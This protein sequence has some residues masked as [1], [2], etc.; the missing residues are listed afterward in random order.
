MEAV[1]SRNTTKTFQVKRLILFIFLGLVDMLCFFHRSCPSVTCDDMAKTY[2]VDVSRLSLFSSMYFYSFTVIV[3]F[4][5]LFADIMEPA[6]LLSTATFIAALGSVVCGLS[7]TLLV[8]CIGRLIVGFGCGLVYAPC[9]RI[10]TNWFPLKYY[11]TVA[12]IFGSIAAVGGLAG[13]GPMVA[14]SK[15]AGW[16]WC[17]FTVA[18]V[19][20]VFALLGFIFLRGHPR[21]CGFDPVNEENEASARL[22]GTDKI[23]IKDRLLVL[24]DNVKT[25][26][27]KR[28]FWL[29]G[30]W[31][32]FANGGFYS[33][34]G[35]W[36]GP[37]LTDVLH[38][39]AQKAG[40][41]VMA[42]SV[43]IITGPLIWPA[44]SNCL[45]TRKWVIF[46]GTLV[47]LIPHMV[48]ILWPTKLNFWLVVVMLYIFAACTNSLCGCAYPLARE[49][50]HSGASAT[51]VGLTN[52][53]GFMSSAIYQPIT[54]H[55]IAKFKI[56]GTTEYSQEGYTYTVWLFSAV[57]C[58][59]GVLC[60]LF[61]KDTDVRA[62]MNSQGYQ[63]IDDEQQSLMSQ[64]TE[65]KDD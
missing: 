39:D 10:L 55:L 53:L 27:R 41:A 34:N 12:G 24:A 46:F 14:L 23:T 38:Y 62:L 26:V 51:A 61:A 54:G 35:M 8:G 9:V 59:V 28:D 25:V 22:S 42:I 16:S 6:F 4:A 20:T 30:A 58:V 3:P 21:K 18:I 48:F 31:V 7:K 47:S 13:Q 64:M 43:G 11:P 60:I 1:K 52:G 56:P 65:S 57:S 5:G 63:S 17:Y 2:G 32:F 19:G 49:Y 40:N 15:A 45:H 50:F 29:V 33:V 37:F 36:S 44:V